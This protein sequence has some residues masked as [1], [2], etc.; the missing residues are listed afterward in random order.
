MKN[1][2]LSFDLVKQFEWE[3]AVAWEDDR[4]D[5]G[6]TRYCALGYIDTRLY[7]VVFTYRDEKVR[8]IS[9]KGG[10]P[11]SMLFSKNM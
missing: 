8:V 6:E 5:Y 10:K 4:M 3:S 7:H 1:R 2:N 11:K 9:L